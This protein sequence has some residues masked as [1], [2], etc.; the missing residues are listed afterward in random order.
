MTY[1]NFSCFQWHFAH[2]KLLPACL[3]HINDVWLQKE[4]EID[5]YKD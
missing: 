4:I 3:Q 5:L 1:S 2:S